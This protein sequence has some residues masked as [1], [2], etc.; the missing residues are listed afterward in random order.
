VWK[1][2]SP[3]RNI[4]HSTPQLPIHVWYHAHGTVVLCVALLPAQCGTP[5]E[6][7]RTKKQRVAAA[8]RRSVNGKHAAQLRWGR[9]PR[10]L[11]NPPFSAAL[12]PRPP[13]GV[14]RLQWEADRARL[15]E[16]R[17]SLS[18]LRQLREKEVGRPW[19]IEGTINIIEAVLQLMFQF[20]L[21]KSAACATVA[22]NW[23][24]RK[25]KV[26]EVVNKWM[27]SRQL[28]WSAPRP[29]GQ[30]SPNY[31]KKFQELN[32]IDKILISDWMDDVN[33]K[34]RVVTARLL[35]TYLQERGIN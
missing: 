34:G 14:S 17:E 18:A 33:E 24:R 3:E 7:R 26:I 16:H 23:H 29:S 19:T 31:P 30:G 15:V 25:E 6:E 35:Q 22:D 10:P 11:P 27:E 2:P 20:D 8:I 1:V 5:V 28:L 32:D 12:G 13:R 9:T 21:S 4:T